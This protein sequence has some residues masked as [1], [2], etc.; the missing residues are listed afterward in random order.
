LVPVACPAALLAVVLA[1]I[2][3]NILVP[4]TWVGLVSGREIAHHG[5]PTV[6]HL[7]VLGQG[8]RWVDQQWLAQLGLYAAERA[9]GGGLRNEVDR[10]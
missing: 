8:N 3:R 2:G 10:Q 6:E 1:G 4:D 5:L 9:R 7:T